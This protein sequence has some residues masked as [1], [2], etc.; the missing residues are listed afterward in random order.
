MRF[1]CRALSL[2]VGLRAAHVAA[3]FQP[4]DVDKNNLVKD[5]HHSNSEKA[6]H[7][8]HHAVSAD[9]HRSL[10]EYDKDD[11]FSMLDNPVV[12]FGV[13]VT[14]VALL[15]ACY[16]LAIGDRSGLQSMLRY[17]VYAQSFTIAAI[18]GGVVYMQI[19][20]DMQKSKTQ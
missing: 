3:S 2:V 11:K 15:G 17:R 1:C 4:N 9:D 18:I 20:K 7:T 6:I 13:G 5:A 16:K 19:K 8:H 12:L 14:V 10:E